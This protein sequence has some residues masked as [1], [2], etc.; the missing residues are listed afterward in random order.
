MSTS[1]PYGPPPGAPP[2]QQKTNGLAVASLILGILWVWWVGS[3]LAVIFGHVAL[4]QIKKTGAAGRGLAVAGLVLGYIGIG[5]ALLVSVVMLAPGNGDNTDSGA[6]APQES[7]STVGP[8]SKPSQSIPGDGTFRV[9]QDVQP[10]TYRT[11]GGEPCYWARLRNL[12]GDLDSILAN[13]NPTG[14]TTV[15]IRSTDKGFETTG[16]DDWQKVG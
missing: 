3:V 10:G 5:I 11:P 16:C 9:P 13:G 2:S 15:T 6:P 8:A 7:M 12:S 4:S 14:P 1:Q